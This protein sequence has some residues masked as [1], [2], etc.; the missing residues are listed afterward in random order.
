MVSSRPDGLFE[1][2]LDSLP[3]AGPAGLFRGTMSQRDS[4]G[5]T[6]R[7]FLRAVGA[8]AI[9]AALLDRGGTGVAEAA[10]GDWLQYSHNSGNSG[11]VPE[12]AGPRTST[13]G[14][15]T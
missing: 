10:S 13:A 15:S 8:T 9:S 11:Y 2:V 14:R 3:V 7:R 6:R 4:T 12:S 5:S 1:G